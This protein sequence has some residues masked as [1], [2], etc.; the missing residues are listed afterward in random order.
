M[1]PN[2][3][4]ISGS[5]DNINAGGATGNWYHSTL[6]NVRPVNGTDPKIASQIKK[7]TGT[8][9][10]SL[11]RGDFCEFKGKLKVDPKYGASVAVDSFELKHPQDEMGVIHFLS[12][13]LPGIGEEIGKRIF[14]QFGNDIFTILDQYPERLTEIKGISRAKAQ[15]IIAEYQER[16]LFDTVRKEAEIFFSQ[17]GITPSLRKK[18][19]Q[20]YYKEKGSD[21]HDD[22]ETNAVIIKNL[23]NNPYRYADE[24]KGIGFKIA[25]KIGKS[26]GI[27]IDSAFRI[28]CGLTYVLGSGF[29]ENAGHSYLP[30]NV[31]IEESAKQ[32]VLDISKKLV[33][34]QIEAAVEKGMIVK[35]GDKYYFPA[36]YAAENLVARKLRELARLP[37]C[38]SL[39]EL[40]E[41]DLLQLDPYQ[42]K[43]VL[44]AMEQRALI[45][46]GGPGVGKT[47]T[48]RMILQAIKGGDTEIALAAPTGAAAK[49]MTQSTKRPATTIHRLLEYHP[50]QGFRRNAE[51]KLEQD[52]V[53]IDEFSMIDI[54]LAA[55][56]FAAIDPNRTQVIM[57][58]DKDQLPSVGVGNVLNDIIKSRIIPVCELKQQHR[59][60]AGSS[61]SRNAALVNAG[62]PVTFDDEFSFIECEDAKVMP[63]MI[64]DLCK[65]IHSKG[66]EKQNIQILC[67]FKS[68]FDICADALNKHLRDFFVKDSIKIEP[69]DL[70]KYS[71]TYQGQFK[72]GSGL[73]VSGTWFKV[74]DKVIQTR[75]N[76]AL[77]IFNGDIGQII[78][79]IPKFLIIEFSDSIIQYPIEDIK[80][81]MLA[82][83]LTVHKSQGSEYSTVIIPIHTQNFIMLNRNLFYTAITRGKDHVIVIGQ[84]KA[85]R[86]AISTPNG[87]IRFS[88]LTER[89]IDGR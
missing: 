70:L 9:I 26:V 27:P 19:T 52:V 80:D 36:V 77:E 88:G 81:L 63:D 56:L 85:V 47:H 14:R 21:S 39:K 61:I 44:L 13:N 48:L 40:T 28:R 31:L 18:L 65:K 87:S 78:G 66:R 73:P 30:L 38:R 86:I 60:G 33:S 49:R 5:I 64:L 22:A 12:E 32:E 57:I 58:G 84:K 71:I 4:T 41:K 16:K 37:L 75:N 54:H 74:G 3:V 62:Q 46:T 1:Q 25:D 34:D 69:L 15:K 7:V 23:K 53:V 20:H 24:V 10:G 72:T 45:V 50:F 79:F 29:A 2:I 17:H 6:I 11:K 51:N 35:D 68:K 89:M 55:A 83:A 76:Y 8:I 67:P 43:A 59:Q 42:R 82:Y